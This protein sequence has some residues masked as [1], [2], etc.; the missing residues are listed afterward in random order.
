MGKRVA[1]RIFMPFSLERDGALLSDEWVEKRIEFFEKYCLNSLLNQTF[2]DF[3]VWLMCGIHNK[4]VT[5]NHDWHD[6]IQ[7]VYD[8]NNDKRGLN[9]FL[10]KL[11]TDYLCVSR[12]DSDDMYRYDAMETIKNFAEDN[13]SNQIEVAAC[14]QNVDWD[15][16]NW[17]LR[18]HFRRRPPFVTKVYPM[19]LYKSK[20]RVRNTM[21]VSHGSLGGQ[22]AYQLPKWSICV[23]KHDENISN[24]TQ[25]GEAGRPNESEELQKERLE[26]GTYF[27]IDKGKCKE[28]LKHYGVNV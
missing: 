27:C 11:D 26:D 1:Y 18:D 25:R 2:Q 23:I 5:D 10:N 28:F 15:M 4:E 12:L 3:K 19:R 7:L 20:D 24:Y 21:W 22:Y 17:N 6:K 14:R 13:L 9:P 16:V 8:T